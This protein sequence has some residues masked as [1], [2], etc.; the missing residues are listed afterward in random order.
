MTKIFSPPLVHRQLALRHE[1]Q[2]TFE[3]RIEYRARHIER[4]ND[5]IGHCN[6]FISVRLA[7]SE[8]FM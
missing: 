8:R 4:G 2:H 1:R 6:D 7:K 3:S 5:L